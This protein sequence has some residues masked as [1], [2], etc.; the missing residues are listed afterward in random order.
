MSFEDAVWDA[1]E[2]GPGNPR[3][4]AERLTSRVRDTLNYLAD[5]GK[6]ARDG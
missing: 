4:I 6:I 3:E 2:R 5:N 1:L